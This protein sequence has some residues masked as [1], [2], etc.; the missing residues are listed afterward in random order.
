[1]EIFS[2]EFQLGPIYIE[3]SVQ[4]TDECTV[5]FTAKDSNSSEI[6]WRTY[7]IDEKGKPKVYRS[8]DEAF[9]DAQTRLKIYN[10]NGKS[11]IEV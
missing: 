3:L 10:P 5:I 8:V 2:K 11:H 7:L 9:L 4:E 6:L 1:M